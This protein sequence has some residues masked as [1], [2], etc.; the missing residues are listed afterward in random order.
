MTFVVTTP[1]EA[2]ADPEGIASG[3]FWPTIE[4]AK[5]REAQR[6]DDTIH[7]NRLLEALF[8]AMA[9]VN[10]ELKAWSEAKIAAGVNKL[11]DV[12]AEK[13]NDVSIHVHRYRRA[14]GCLAKANLLER[15]RDFDAT[16]RGDRKADALENPIDDLRRDARWAISDI[17]GI[18]RT[19][20]ELI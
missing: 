20:V 12:E 8:E 18:G 6:I 13:I 4:P 15:Y 19:T 2:P 11:E 14:V 17:Q 16:A 3:P 1:S 5:V 7:P 10:A 9:S